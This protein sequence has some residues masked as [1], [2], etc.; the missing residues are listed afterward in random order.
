[1]ANTY[2][3]VSAQIEEVDEED[4][5]LDTQRRAALV[6]CGHAEN[7]AEAREFMDM[8]GLTDSLGRER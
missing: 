6:A 7:V 1:M 5:S 8:L 3:D 2:Q 4:V